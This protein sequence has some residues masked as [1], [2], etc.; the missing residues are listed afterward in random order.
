[1][2]VWIHILCEYAVKRKTILE[3]KCWEVTIDRT[4]VEVAVR[5]NAKWV[6]NTI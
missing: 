4:L 2:F 5:I 6:R 3:S 1:M